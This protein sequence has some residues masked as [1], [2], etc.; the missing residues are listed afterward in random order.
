MSHSSLSMYLANPQR[1]YKIYITDYPMPRME[2]TQA[3][4]V[5]SAF[6][7]YVKSYLVTTLWEKTPEEFELENILVAQVSA[8]NLEWARENGKYAFD[9]YR[10]CGALADL[11]QDLATSIIKPRFEFK[12]TGDIAGVPVLGYPDLFFINEQEARIVM[13]FKVN[14]YCSARPVSPKRG[15]V[16]VRPG[17]DKQRRPPQLAVVKGVRINISDYF[18]TIDKSWCQQNT[19]YAWLMGEKIG[20]DF[21][22]GIEQIACSPGFFFPKIRVASHRGR[23]SPKYQDELAATLVDAWEHVQA[24]TICDNQD[25]LEAECKAE[26]EMLTE[27]KLWG[28]IQ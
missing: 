17:P 9:Q 27:N 15:Y 11:T 5:G 4:S 28:K 24:G 22:I 21:I 10:E 7:A 26:F 2:Q 19:L 6:D 8:A 23:P 1:Y 13:D 18:E 3:M 20:S 25:E 12:L 16:K 14:G